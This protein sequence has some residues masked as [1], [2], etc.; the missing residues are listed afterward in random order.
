[1]CFCIASRAVGSCNSRL[2]VRV[3]GRGRC[4]RP[5]LP[6]KP[7]RIIAPF[8]PGGSTDILARLVAQK[9]TEGLGQQAIVENRAGGGSVIGTEIVAKASPDGYTLLMASTSTVYES[10]SVAQAAF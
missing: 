6:V 4:P 8:A 9:L 1:M 5:D 2:A 7:I 3:S 10:Q